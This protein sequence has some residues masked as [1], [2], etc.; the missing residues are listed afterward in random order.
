MK[1]GIPKGFRLIARN[2]KQRALKEL[3]T[4]FIFYVGSYHLWYNFVSNSY[5]ELKTGPQQHFFFFITVAKRC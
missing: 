3:Q 5:Y 2:T 1:K 4:A